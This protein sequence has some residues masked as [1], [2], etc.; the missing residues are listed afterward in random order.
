MNKILKT[1]K[2][3]AIG[4]LAG[5]S[6]YGANV[7]C[8]DNP[9]PPTYNEEQIQLQYEEY[10]TREKGNDDDKRTQDD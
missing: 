6:I 4:T 3:A 9:L 2:Y 10:L 1:L 7:A 5:L 8:R